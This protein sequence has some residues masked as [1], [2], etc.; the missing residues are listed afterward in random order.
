[1]SELISDGVA[2]LLEDWEAELPLARD[3][4]DISGESVIVTLMTGRLVAWIPAAGGV[5][6]ALSVAEST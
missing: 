5:G 6:G 1:M 4:E 2:E 3:F